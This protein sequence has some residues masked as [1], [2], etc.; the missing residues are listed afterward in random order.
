MAASNL[1][2]GLTFVLSFFAAAIIAPAPSNASDHI[3]GLKTAVD[4]AADLSD[5]FAFTS[6]KDSSKLV[7][8]MNVHSIAFSGSKFSDAVDYKF[9]IR[10]IDDPKT[11]VPSPDGKREQSIVCS[12]K[13]V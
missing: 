7:L 1:S 11:L 10:P 13:S 2:K 5:V 8:I 12:F 6:P 4:N 3:D 9:R